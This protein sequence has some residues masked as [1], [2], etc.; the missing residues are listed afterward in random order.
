[1]DQTFLILKQKNGTVISFRGVD[2]FKVSHSNENEDYVISSR[3]DTTGV[4]RTNRKNIIFLFFCLISFPNELDCLYYN[5]NSGVKA[6]PSVNVSVIQKLKASSWIFF[7]YFTCSS[8]TINVGFLKLLVKWNCMVL[9]YR[10]DVL[11]STSIK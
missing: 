1:M 5:R 4:C 10:F 8:R 9:T 3:N 11:F 2:P 7:T 6:P